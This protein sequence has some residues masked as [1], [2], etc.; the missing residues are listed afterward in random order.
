[1][2]SINYSAP[3][4]FR[5]QIGFYEPNFSRA[6]NHLSHMEWTNYH[7]FSELT[8]PKQNKTIQFLF[9]HFKLSL[10]HTHTS[11]GNMCSFFLFGFLSATLF[12]TL[13]Y[14]QEQTCDYSRTQVNTS[15]TWDEKLIAVPSS[16]F[17]TRLHSTD[18][19]IHIHNLISAVRAKMLFIN[20][21][22]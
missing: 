1:M 15:Q 18:S 5:P 8:Q 2:T 3:A 17:S 19:N 13:A 14:I 7:R 6:P 12:T 4:H 21:P 9:H 22:Y 10:I 20:K 16:I 11:N